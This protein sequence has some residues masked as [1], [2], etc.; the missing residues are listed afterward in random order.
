MREGSLY[1]FFNPFN[2]DSIPAALSSRRFCSDASRRESSICLSRAFRFA[3][4]PFVFARRAL[5]YSQIDDNITFE[6]YKYN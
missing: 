4:F 1:L 5:R 6:E 2:L 3:F